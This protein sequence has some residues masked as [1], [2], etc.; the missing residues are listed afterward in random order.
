M[1]GNFLDPDALDA[2]IEELWNAPIQVC[3]VTE[4]HV[5]HPNTKDGSLTRCAMCFEAVV[6]PVGFE[7]RFGLTSTTRESKITV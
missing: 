3:G 7:E 6:I 2:L 5:F 4:P 1:E